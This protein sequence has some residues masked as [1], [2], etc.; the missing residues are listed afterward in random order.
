LGLPIADPRKNREMRRHVAYVGE[1]KQLYDYLTVEQLIRFTSSFYADW[2]SDV[3]KRL[4]RSY[5]LDSRKKIGHL[6]K[7]M[8][9]RLALL[10]ALA[11][12]PDLLIL[13]EPSDGLDPVAIEEFLQAVIAI[14]GEVE[15]IADQVCV[16]DHGA[17][18]AELSLDEVRQ[19]YRRITMGFAKEPPADA[20]AVYGVERVEIN[21]RQMTVWAH[22]NAADIVEHA[23]GMDAVSVDASPLTLREVFLE[24][25]KEAQ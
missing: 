18:V 4:Q 11:R 17:L 22:H 3:A 5:E 10:L 8:R 7:G 19:E 15:R 12:Q 6:S 14:A 20:F 13:D 16:I 25:V 21:G 9:T 1:E 2:R 23:R 24:R